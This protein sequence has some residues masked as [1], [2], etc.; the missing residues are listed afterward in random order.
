MSNC[1]TLGL[2]VPSINLPDRIWGKYL[3]AHARKQLSFGLSGSKFE[4]DS[5]IDNALDMWW[6]FLALFLV[7]I[8]EKE[9]LE[10]NNNAYW[11]NIFAIGVELE[12]FPCGIRL[13]YPTVFELTSAYGT[14]GLSLGTP[15]VS[16]S[17]LLTWFMLTCIIAGELLILRRTATSLKVDHLCGYDT[18]E[19]Q[20]LTSRHRSSRPPAC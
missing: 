13:R 9:S 17:H 15:N 10:D 7:C 6:L 14:V 8:V 2:S 5:S 4:D 20:R 16:E 19:T 12:S 11:F 18:W 3:A 1:V